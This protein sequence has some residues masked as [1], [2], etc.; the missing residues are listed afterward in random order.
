MLATLKI[1][2]LS[3]QRESV[4]FWSLSTLF[5]TLILLKH[6]DHSAFYIDDWTIFG[7]R[8]GHLENLGFDDFVLRRHN[9]HLMGGMVLWDVGLAK[10]FGLRNYIPWIITIQIA[11]S[12][13]SWVLYRYM[14]RIGITALVSAIIAPF[15]MIWAPINPIAYWAPEAIFTISLACVMVHFG[16]LVLA[17]SS[18]K[19]VV[20]GTVVALLGIFIHSICVVLIPISVFVLFIQRK[21][22]SSLIASIPLVMYGFWYL[23]YQKLPQANRWSLLSSEELTQVRN[24]NLFFESTWKILS[25]TMWLNSSPLIA[26]AFFALVVI[27]LYICIGRG[28][29]QRLIAI[30]AVVASCILLM[31]IAWSRA[32][33]MKL[34]Q[35]EPAS[36][37]A[38]VIFVL[39]FPLALLPIVIIGRKTRT[40]LRLP[41]KLLLVSTIMCIFVATLLNFS[42]SQQFDTE[43]TQSAESFMRQ[44]QQAADDSKLGLHHPD[45]FVFGDNP[46]IDITHGDIA[47]LLRLGWL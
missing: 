45:E 2:R 18:R 26:F 35:Q 21:W 12:L 47:R 14:V 6:L 32:Y 25:R 20:F 29:D 27:G 22:R 34:M 40:L 30:S 28:G 33:F 8:L 24:V 9:E 36:R 37:Y 1:S 3:L 17:T 43:F 16:C 7:S 11:N 13:V 44:I 31:G 41:K 4:V 15:F 23:T 39:L 5:G 38:A 42:L 46:W 10:A 19:A